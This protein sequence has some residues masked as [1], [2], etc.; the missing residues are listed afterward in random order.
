MDIT[1]ERFEDIPGYRGFYQIGSLG[2]VRSVTRK[3]NTAT[4]IRVFCG[5]S[6]KLMLTRK[7][8]YITVCLCKNNIKQTVSV[9]RLVAN[10]FVNNPNKKG[11]VNHRNSD[12]ADNRAENLEWCSKQEN[13][14]YQKKSKI[15]NLSSIYKGVSFDKAT[16]KWKSTI[17]KNYKITNIGRFIDEKM[18]AIAY[19]RKAEE[20]FGKF[21]LLNEV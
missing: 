6:I 12:R 2:N 4:G 19:N 20:L 18:A 21:A 13:T 11:F 9:H 17:V 16:G 14:W 8:K 7:D 1:I 3:I 10:A 5:N 15:G